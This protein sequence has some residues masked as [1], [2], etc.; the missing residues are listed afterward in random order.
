MHYNTPN[1]R[2]VIHV[3]YYIQWQIIIIAILPGVALY[4]YIGI[5]QYIFQ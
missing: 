5:L 2:T 4:T 1:S 3:Y